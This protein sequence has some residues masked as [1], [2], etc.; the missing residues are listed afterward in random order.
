[1][2]AQATHLGQREVVRLLRSILKQE[3]QA[4]RELEAATKQLGKELHP[5]SQRMRAVA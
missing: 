4:V 1:V 2:V 5:G 3:E